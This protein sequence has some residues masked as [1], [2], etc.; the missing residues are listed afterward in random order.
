MGDRQSND[1]DSTAGRVEHAALRP[2]PDRRPHG[3]QAVMVR[4]FWA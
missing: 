1:A 2:S 3:H 4:L